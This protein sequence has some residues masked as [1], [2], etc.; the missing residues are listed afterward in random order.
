MISIGW[1]AKANLRPDARRLASSHGKSG[2]AKQVEIIHAAHRD[3]VKP[4]R[5]GGS[6]EMLL[7]RLR[8]VD[9]QDIRQARRDMSALV[10][11]HAEI[12]GQERLPQ[13]SS[14][15][16]LNVGQHQPLL[17]G[18]ILKPFRLGFLRAARQHDHDVTK[19]RPCAGFGNRDSS[20]VSSNKHETLAAPARLRLMGDLFG[21][22][23]PRA[24]RRMKSPALPFLERCG[25]LIP[26]SG[27]QYIRGQPEGGNGDPKISRRS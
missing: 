15:G 10:E 6:V 16:W 3:P 13:L 21:C 2:T 27:C 26:V 5:R 17:Y 24:I 1:R 19:R 9:E 11:E 8:Y 12:P 4:H 20:S 25:G 22:A 7:A 23:G 18:Q 14:C